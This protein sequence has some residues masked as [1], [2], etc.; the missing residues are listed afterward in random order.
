MTQIAQPG[1]NDQ[2]PTGTTG[3]AADDDAL[4]PKFAQ[5]IKAKRRALGNDASST[6]ERILDAA[7]E[8]FLAQGYD[9][10][11]LRQIAEQLGVTKAALYYHFESKEDILRALHM[12]LHEFGK[13]ALDIVGDEPMT[14]EL[15]GHLLDQLV[16]QMLAQ[17]QLFLMHQRNQAALEKLHNEEHD[18][19][20]DDIQNQFRKI[21]LDTRVPERDR[22]RMAAAFGAAFAGLF[23]AG[24]SFPDSD[25]AKLGD[26][27]RECIGDVIS[28]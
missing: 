7:L 11:S 3:P 5:A 28:G 16:D 14:L 13:D 2:D 22:V 12:R 27:L 19:A 21:L 15:W 8:L 25:T 18:A 26:M 10:T 6:R 9:G 23:L 20:H 17:S 1:T 4:P 24:E